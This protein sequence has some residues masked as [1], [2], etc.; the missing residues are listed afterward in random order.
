VCFLPDFAFC[1]VRNKVL[2]LINMSDYRV[3]VLLAEGEDS[4]CLV[5]YR[6]EREET[7]AE[8]G[9]EEGPRRYSGCRRSELYKL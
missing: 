1:H 9:S 2:V 3:K 7:G 5:L 4:G 8:R 6:L